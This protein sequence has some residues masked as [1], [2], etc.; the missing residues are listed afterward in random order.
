MKHNC[1]R[2]NSFLKSINQEIIL[3]TIL[4]LITIF[5]RFYNIEKWF[6]LNQDEI[7]VIER[8]NLPLL[9]SGDPSGTYIPSVILSKLFFVNKFSELRYVSAFINSI[10]V[11]LVYFTMKLFVDWKK[12]IL[13]TLFLS[14]HWY[15]LFMSRIFEQSS[16]NMLLVIIPLYLYFK[17]KKTKNGLLIYIAFIFLG[18]QLLNYIPLIAYFG[19]PFFLW[20]IYQTKKGRISNKILYTSIF[21]FFLISIPYLCASLFYQ[22]NY[23]QF[24]YIKWIYQKLGISYNS[25]YLLNAAKYNLT[26]NTLTETLLLSTQHFPLIIFIIVIPLVIYLLIKLNKKERKDEN[27][28]FLCWMCYISLFLVI[29]SPTPIYGMSHFIP[30]LIFFVFFLVKLL[31]HKWNYAIMSI[32]FLLLIFNISWLPQINKNEFNDLEWLKI[33]IAK[34]DIKEIYMQTNL[35]RMVEKMDI[36][37][38]NNIKTFFCNELNETLNQFNESKIIILYNNPFQG[39]S[40]LET[41]KYGLQTFVQSEF[42]FIGKNLPTS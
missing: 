33:Y 32:I 1:R 3:F 31:E 29:V 8:L 37:P 12:S 9:E 38:K 39:C 28:D 24:E 26:L 20:I 30:F 15:L 7:N 27:L 16:L 2:V 34:N 25:F 19:P 23:N 4:L 17:W 35:Y 22:E 41:Q 10:S 21:I 40:L 11:I 13:G 18:I 36:F 5:I 42:I 14:I 6:L